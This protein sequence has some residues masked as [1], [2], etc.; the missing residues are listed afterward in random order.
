[1]FAPPISASAK[2]P[3][4]VSATTDSRTLDDS[5]L[6]DDADAT[7]ADAI[8][9]ALARA[10]RRRPIP[11]V[12]RLT[13]LRGKY[14]VTEFKSETD[15]ERMD[16]LRDEAT[17]FWLAADDPTAGDPTA[18][19]TAASDGSASIPVATD[20]RAARA[21]LGTL[22][23]GWLARVPF[24]SLSAEGIRA[25]LDAEVRSSSGTETRR[26]AETRRDDEVPRGEE[27]PRDEETL[28]DE[29]IEAG[30][31]AFFRSEWGARLQAAG[32]RIE[33]EVPFSLKWTVDELCH[34][35]PAL[36]QEIEALDDWSE[37]EWAAELARHWALLQGRLDCVFPYEDGWVVLDWKTDRVNAS[38]IDARAETY[39]NQMRFYRDAVRKLW[40][41]PVTSVLVFVR[42]GDVRV[43]GGR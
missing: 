37:A 22:Y 31:E 3:S 36:R 30:L 12:A 15:F 11:P 39:A 42:T 34:A 18:D 28:R 5:D 25:A 8:D 9:A 38:T 23:H 14:W 41:G 7:D 24:A 29:E 26:G 10:A 6:E 21:S 27:I 1:M 16:A 13:L 43:T 35:L 40:G 19:G 17:A 2:S 32:E 20:S 33:R 4:V